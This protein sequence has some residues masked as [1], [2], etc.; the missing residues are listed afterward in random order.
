M[1]RFLVSS[2]WVFAASLVLVLAFI[3]FDPRLSESAQA[4]PG[5][6]VSFNRAITDF[7]TFRWMLYSTG[8]LAILAY[9]AARV[10]KAQTYNGRLRTA[11]RLLAYFFLTIGTASILVH[12]LKFLIGRA[13]PELLLE[14]G[15]YSLTPFTGDNLYESF[16]SG[17]ST[18]AGVFFGAFAMLMPRFRWVF[19]LLA[20][21]I[22]V[23]RV[24]VGAHYPSD[25]AAGLLLGMWTAMAFAFI[26]ARSEMLFRFD[27]HGWPQPKNANLPT[28][29]TR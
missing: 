3:P 4:L 22:G 16:P 13:R 26:F 25:V 5:G 23:S 19:L 7:G 1:R 6:V 2:G 18:A 24:I 14:M 29:D 20:L 9:V 21:V 12:T 8:L 10:L 15:A 17:H 27:A 11:W 28:A